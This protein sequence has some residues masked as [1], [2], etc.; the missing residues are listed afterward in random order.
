MSKGS[1]QCFCRTILDLDL[2]PPIDPNKLARVNAKYKLKVGHW[3]S[4]N[5]LQNYKIYA[6]VIHM[7][8]HIKH[9]FRSSQIILWGSKIE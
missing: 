2:Y 7:F 6:N 1:E 5:T 4:S 9:I 8:I 3:A